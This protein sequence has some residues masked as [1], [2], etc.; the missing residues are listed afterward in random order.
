MISVSALSCNG[1]TG[2]DLSEKRIGRS[3][4]PVDLSKIGIRF[5]SKLLQRA[6]KQGTFVRVVGRVAMRTRS[7]SEWSG[8]GKESAVLKALT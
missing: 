1:F 6:T 3:R 8:F 2:A 4:E 5:C 7:G